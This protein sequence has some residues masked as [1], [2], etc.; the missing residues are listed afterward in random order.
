MWLGALISGLQFQINFWGNQE[1]E[2]IF[3]R[4]NYVKSV[5][6]LKLFSNYTRVKSEFDAFTNDHPF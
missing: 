6:E 4:E 5:N 3:L 1:P 2:D